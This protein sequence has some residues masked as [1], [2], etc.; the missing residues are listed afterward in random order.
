MISKVPVTHPFCML[1]SF[2]FYEGVK[3]KN[4]T[5]IHTT[6][7]NINNEYLLTSYI[8]EKFYVINIYVGPN[9]L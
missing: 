4:Q 6:K 2:P 5:K 7:L 1:A 3:A 9:V 8:K